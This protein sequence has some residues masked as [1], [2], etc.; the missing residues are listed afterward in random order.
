MKVYA[1]R[2]TF[3]ALA[4]L[5]LALAVRAW[6]LGIDAEGIPHSIA[7]LI[8]PI[9]S[10]CLVVFALLF[11]VCAF[12]GDPD[13]KEDEGLRQDFFSA[14]SVSATLLLMAAWVLLAAGT[15]LLVPA[16]LA[17][18]GLSVVGLHLGFWGFLRFAQAIHSRPG[19]DP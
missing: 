11:G 10:M 16:G 3:A 6:T 19:D 8:G 2:P 4:L 12:V 17:G 7:P 18:L 5:S 14:R 1:R 13:S 9:H 15:L